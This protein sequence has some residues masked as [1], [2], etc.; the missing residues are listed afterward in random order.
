VVDQRLLATETTGPKKKKKKRE[1]EEKKSPM[2]SIVGNSV[3]LMIE[4]IRE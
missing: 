1:E 4:F 3:L 2:L